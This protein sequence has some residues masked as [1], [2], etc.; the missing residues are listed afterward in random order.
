MTDDDEV[1]LCECGYSYDRCGCDA[2]EQ[3]FPDEYEPWEGWS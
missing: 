2:H 1:E 3:E